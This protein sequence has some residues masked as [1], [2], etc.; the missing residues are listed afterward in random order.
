M[1][2]AKGITKRFRAPGGWIAA[3]DGVSLALSPG[4][5]LGLLGPSGSGKST[6][7]RIL[8]LLLRPDSGAVE[9]DGVDIKAWGIKALGEI[10]RSVQLV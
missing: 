7:A 6:L 9:L 2:K 5:H 3:L 1:L 4:E 10:R 8:P